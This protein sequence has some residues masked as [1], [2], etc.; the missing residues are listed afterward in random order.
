MFDHP[1]V[2][3]GTDL[4][5]SLKIDSAGTVLATMELPWKLAMPRLAA[6]PERVIFVQSMERLQLD[7]IAGELSDFDTVVG[8]GGGSCMDFAK[9]LAWKRS[10][11]LILIPSIAS[12]D[13]CV[14]HSIAVRESGRV[15]YVG[16]I[17]A[18]DILVDYTLIS[19]AP[20]RLNR[21][22][23]ADI[24][25]IHTGSFDWLL[26]ADKM[27]EAYSDDIARQCAEAVQDLAKNAVEIRNVSHAGIRTLIKLFEIENDLCLEHG[28][29]RP[30]EGSEHFFAYNAE[31]MTGKHFIHGE[32]VCLGILLM[33]RLQKNRPE[34]V[35][36]LLDELGVLYRPADIGLEID[37]LRGTLLTLADYCR[38]E[39]LPYTIINECELSPSIVD[40][41]ISDLA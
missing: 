6:A 2:Q 5:E 18:E 30:E 26:A 19:A 7:K 12:V 14:T 17:R 16:D 41:L 40:E 10:A 11:R 21:A 8:I 29:S 27:D 4:I 13:A 31:H 15:C 20:A 25:S 32:L 33:S 39:K 35:K 22:G 37:E 36:T 9:Y 24:L 34:W 23:A 38:K 28:N 3:F 1:E